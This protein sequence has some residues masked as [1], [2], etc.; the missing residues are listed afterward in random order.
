MAEIDVAVFTFDEHKELKF[1]NGRG[2]ASSTSL[3][4]GCSAAMP[5]RSGS[6]T[7]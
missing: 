6:P 7:A 2:P 1:V 3:P 4:S 5:T